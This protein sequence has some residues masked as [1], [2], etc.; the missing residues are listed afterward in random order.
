MRALELEEPQASGS[1][2]L[3]LY[4]INAAEDFLGLDIDYNSEFSAQGSNLLL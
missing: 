4:G 3:L 2:L 1:F